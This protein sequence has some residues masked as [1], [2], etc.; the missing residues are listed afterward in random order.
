MAL[1]QTGHMSLPQS[2]IAGSTFS[3]STTGS[4]KAVLYIV[5]PGQVLRRDV[6]LGETASFPTGTLYNAGHYLAILADPSSSDTGEFDVTPALR[7]ETL[8]FFAKPSRLP[9]GLHNGI[10]GAVYVFD[11]YRNLITMPAAVSFALSNASGTLQSRTL[12]T[13]NGVA[14]TMMDSAAKQ[15]KV[16]FIARVDGVTS[17]RIIEEVPGDPCRLTISARPINGKI[18]VQTAPVRDCSGNQIPDGTIVTFTATYND[19]QST[20]DVPI[21]QGIAT[22]DMPAY[23]GAK[24]SVASGIVAGNEIQWTGGQ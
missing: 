3:I 20:V 17:T 13:R 4:G 5:G 16:Q 8:S 6:Q 19:T 12:N 15:G 14:W 24:I 18:R 9:V 2:V 10:S 1:S 21:K 23:K 22:V 11:A 7:P